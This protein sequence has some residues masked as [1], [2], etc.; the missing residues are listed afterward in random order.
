MMEKN[1][2]EAYAMFGYISASLK[3]LSPEARMRYS[4]VYCGICRRIREQ[5]SQTARLS[6]S[7]DMAFLALLLMSLYEPEEEG[8][9]SACILHPIKKRPWVDSPFVRYAAD[10]NVALSYYNCLDDWT[11]DGKPAAKFMANRLQESYFAI[12]ERYSRQCQAIEDCITE[13]SR[14][15]NENCADASLT[16]PRS[17]FVFPLT[18]RGKYGKMKVQKKPRTKKH[19]TNGSSNDAPL[20]Q[21]S[22]K[23]GL[24]AKKTA[25]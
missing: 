25:S 16:H 1:G 9:P 13:L 5:A 8:G 4:S 22:C 17:F 20:R 23:E 15:E 19:G 3:E 14:L 7:Y 10:M 2:K 6:L 12:R 18:R 24:C 11:D 21:L